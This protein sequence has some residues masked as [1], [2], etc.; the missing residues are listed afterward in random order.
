MWR[1]N[2]PLT[3]SD[4]RKRAKLPIDNRLSSKSKAQF[5]DWRDNM[6]GQIHFLRV[7]RLVMLKNTQ[8]QCKEQN[9]NINV[10]LFLLLNGVLFQFTVACD[11][12]HDYCLVCKYLLCYI[13]VPHLIYKNVLKDPKSKTNCSVIGLRIIRYFGT[14]H[15]AIYNSYKD[16]T[17]VE[18][19]PLPYTRNEYT[20]LRK[21]NKSGLSLTSYTTMIII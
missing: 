11:I 1:R 16:K 3:P 8:T 21:W 6:V 5:M 12:T 10:V 4:D 18:D 14:P 13:G 19:T 7:F 17:N 20:F 15:E 2:T 9:S